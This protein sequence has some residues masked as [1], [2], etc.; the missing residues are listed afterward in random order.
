MEKYD[1]LKQQLDSSI[2]KTFFKNWKTENAIDAMDS[3]Q[4][5]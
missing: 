3:G 1:K 2:E 5:D 4:I